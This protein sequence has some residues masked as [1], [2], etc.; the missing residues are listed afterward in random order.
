MPKEVYL[1]YMILQLRYLISNNYNKTIKFLLY[2][3]FGYPHC[4][5]TMIY[6]FKLDMVKTL[7][8]VYLQTSKELNTYR[9]LKHLR[10]INVKVGSSI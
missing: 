4:L 1:L 7:E 5:F 2:L 3:N 6:K 8:K 9:N 10:K